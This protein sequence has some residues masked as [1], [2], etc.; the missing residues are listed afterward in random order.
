MHNVTAF[1]WN[2][3]NND[4][5]VYRE[6]KAL[7]DGGYDTTL[8]CLSDKGKGYTTVVDGIKVIKVTMYRQKLLYP[9]SVLT[10]VLQMI[11]YGSR[12]NS[13]VY[14][15]NDLSTLPQAVISKVFS[16]GQSKLIYDSHEI[17]K[18]RLG[19]SSRFV[20]LER[21]LIHSADH[22]IVTNNFRKEVLEKLYPS[23]NISIVHNYSVMTEVSECPF[24]FHQHFDLPLE[25][26][27]I[28]Y[29]GGLQEGRGLTLAIEAMQYVDSAVLVLI[30]KGPLKGELSELVSKYGLE[31]KVHFINMVPYKELYRYTEGADIGLQLLEDTCINHKTALS[32]KLF[33]YMRAE[34][35]V[36][37]SDI[38]EIVKVVHNTSAGIIVN[39]L[40]PTCI[41]DSINQLLSEPLLLENM[42]MNAK[43]SKSKY[44]WKMEQ[45]EYLKLIK[46]D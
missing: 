33:E 3:F 34:V 8:I 38:R 26:K 5:R 13:D 9:I 37:A 17:Q 4:G 35:P 32:N 12:M 36:V 30:G 39:D 44:D 11:M 22:V 16:K 46:D 27:I 2:S 28:L 18:Y 1:V 24:D 15:A 42:R 31:K 40:T 25:L 7:V 21:W 43:K 19:K 6:C 29:Q 23:A 45:A 20:F 10:A 14:H 41:A